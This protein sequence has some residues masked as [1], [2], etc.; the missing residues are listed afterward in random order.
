MYTT[1]TVHRESGESEEGEDRGLE[2]DRHRDTEME[3]VRE[4]EGEEVVKHL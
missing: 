3:R 2:G 4:Q 1:Y